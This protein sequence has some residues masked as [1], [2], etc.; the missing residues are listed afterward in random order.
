MIADPDGAS[1]GGD[2]EPLVATGADPMGGA[3]AATDDEPASCIGRSSAFAFCRRASKIQND[4]VPR[5]TPSSALARA[6]PTSIP[7]SVARRFFSG[8]YV[9]AFFDPIPDSKR[10]AASRTS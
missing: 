2:E 9:R 10:A 5:G 1:R 6:A 7:R 8:V 4:R 3:G